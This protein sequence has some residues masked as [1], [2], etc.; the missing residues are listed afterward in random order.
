MCLTDRHQLMSAQR[1]PL[2]R[3]ADSFSVIGKGTHPR[4]LNESRLVV[5]AALQLLGAF[6]QA[7]SKAAKTMASVETPRRNVTAPDPDRNSATI[8]YRRR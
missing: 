5:F 8:I 7:S 1:Q 4:R 2:R 6:R 3:S